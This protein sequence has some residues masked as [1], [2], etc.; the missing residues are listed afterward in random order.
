M[1]EPEMMFDVAVI[2]AG[3]GGNIAAKICAHSNLKTILVEK[4]A[5]PRDKPCGGWLTPSALQIIYENFGELPKGLVEKQIEEII[6]LPTCRF[7]Q[8]ING[9]SVYRKSFDFWL[10]EKA[11]DEGVMVQNATLK[12]LF[13]REDCVVLNLKSDTS[14]KEINARYVVGADGAGSI[15]RSTLYPTLKTKLAKTYQIYV[16]GQLPRDA[17]YIYFPLKK[18][19]VTYF[20]MIP[21]KEVV[22]L[23]VGGLPPINNKK[24]MQNFFSAMKKRFKLGKI[25]KH[26]AYP[27]PTFSPTDLALGKKRTLLVGDAASLANPFTG[28]GIFG[29][30]MSGKLAARAIIEDF[31]APLYVSKTYRKKLKPLISRLRK[32]HT[33]YTYYQSLNY[34]ERQDTI[35]SYFEAAL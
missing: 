33:M 15:V 8:E 25:L 17:I 23:G 24:L 13:Q 26:E 18:P 3:P 19:Q 7:S 5:L 11:K 1:V 34:K 32:M 20:W 4:N 14:E 9:A 28:E 12:S 30:L 6:L 29:S 16:K 2:G 31:N 27:I 35:K 22:V 10:T 21:K